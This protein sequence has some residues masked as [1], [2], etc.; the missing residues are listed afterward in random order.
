MQLNLLRRYLY[1]DCTIGE[2]FLEGQEDRL[3]WTL[4]DQVRTGPKV[5]G[6]TAIPTGRYKVIVTPSQRFKRDLPLLLDVPGFT[7]IRIH[8]GNT[9]SDTEGCVLV[10]QAVGDHAVTR[11]RAAF[12]PLFR[13]IQRALWTN[14][15]V[16]ITVLNRPYPQMDQG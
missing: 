1:D 6:Q 8:S 13:Q 3:C 16:W 2:L 10:G 4:E 9:A 7:G 5:D 15:A 14:E 11:S 12:T